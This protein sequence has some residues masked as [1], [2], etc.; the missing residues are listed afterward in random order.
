MVHADGEFLW[1]GAYL[2]LMD[3]VSYLFCV[4]VICVYICIYLLLIKTTLEII[5]IYGVWWKCCRILYTDWVMVT[6][7]LLYAEEGVYLYLILRDLWGALLQL[8]CIYIPTAYFHWCA[9]FSCFIKSHSSII[10][11]LVT[12]TYV[13]Q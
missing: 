6:T 13:M 7:V 9:F 1:C 11:Y 5:I 2:M 12:C 3:V 10:S 4:I 8:I